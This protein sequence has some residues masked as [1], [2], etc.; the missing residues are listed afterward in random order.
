MHRLMG[1]VWVVHL[2]SAAILGALSYAIC[3]AEAKELGVTLGSHTAQASFEFFS[4]YVAFMQFARFFRKRQRHPLV[5]ADSAAALGAAMKLSSP[6]PS[7]NFIG[8]EVAIALETQ[9]M[10]EIEADHIPGKLNV[11]ADFLARP[12]CDEV[13]EKPAALNDVSIKKVS[14][15]TPFALEGFGPGPRPDLRGGASRQTEG[16]SSASEVAQTGRFVA[17][18]FQ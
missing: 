11:C 13:P 10:G 1:W 7:M 5:R 2:P 18:L 8:A 15:R 12:M 6:T 3:E 4:F 17:E 16:T 14:L 9:D